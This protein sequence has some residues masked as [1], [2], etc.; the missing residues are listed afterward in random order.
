M[1]S[2]VN[3]QPPT[4][5][6]YN[7]Q[8]FEGTDL[9]GK[10]FPGSWH[11][12]NFRHIFTGPSPVIKRCHQACSLLLVFLTGFI[13]AYAGATFGE[14]FQAP[15]PGSW[16]LGLTVGILLIL[17][18]LITLRNG[19]TAALGSLS[20]VTVFL[21]VITV[22]LASQEIAGLTAL[23]SLVIGGFV[24]GSVGLAAAIT[25]MS[26][27]L[28]PIAIAVLGLVAGSGVGITNTSTA[29]NIICLLVVSISVL[30]LGSY[31]GHQALRHNP[32]YTLLQNLAIRLSTWGSTSFKGSDLTAANFSNATLRHTDFANATLTRTRWHN[33]TFHHN[34]LAGTYL[35]NP[36]IRRLV[37]ELDGEGQNFD[38]LD[39]RGINL[40]GAKLAGASFVGADLSSATLKGAD[41]TNAKLAQAQLYDADL[42]GAVLTGA[43]IENWGISPETN[44]ETIHC[45]YIH[46][47]LPTDD[48]PDPYRKPDKRDEVFQKND[49]TN[50]IAPILNTLKAYRQQSLPRPSEVTLTK[51]LDLY[52]REGIDPTAAAIALQE[53]I[54]QNPQAQIQVLSIGGVDQNIRIE[55]S[56]TPQT[57]PSDLNA[58]Y[59]HRYNQLSTQSSASLQALFETL[60]VQYLQ[61]R[62]L[63]SRLAAATGSAT[64]Y[65]AISL[66]EITPPQRSALQRKRDRLLNAIQQQHRHLD[67]GEIELQSANDQWA[68]TIEESQRNRLQRQITQLE[69]K[70]ADGEERLTELERQIREMPPE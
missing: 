43:Y 66:N 8:N 9:R 37:T 55:A 21:I 45:D 60:A 10:S 57:E 11:H 23:S 6:H 31:L 13:T 20:L 38:R 33:A 29:S 67:D 42:T 53:L 27:K 5:T 32:R 46:L 65:M 19:L 28:F 12:A 7:S 2:A 39:L 24:A 40:D 62:S 14:F 3:S 18:L 41:L 17:F 34:N 64:T 69:K 59:F 49:F 35:A 1:L 68:A 30:S 44:L 47:R 51:T 58:R 48:N 25:L 52:H 16:I 50:F 56:I 63:E 22:A 70:L 36:R 15:D 54:N 4:V 61:L 26:S